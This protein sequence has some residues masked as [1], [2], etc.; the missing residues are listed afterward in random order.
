[1]KNTHRQD[2]NSTS[3][4]PTGGPAIVATPV[5]DVQRPIAWPDFAPYTARSSASEFVVTKAPQTPWRARA[6]I[7]MLP[8]GAAPASAE[9][10]A[11]PMMPAMKTSRRPTRSPIAPPTR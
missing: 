4:P 10:A 1:M 8:F 7:R 5:N 9:A 6:R 11:K 2:A 3:A